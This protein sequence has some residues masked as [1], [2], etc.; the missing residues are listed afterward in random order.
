[1]DPDDRP[2]MAAQRRAQHD[3]L[4]RRANERAAI[5]RQLQASQVGILELRRRREE[6]M[7]QHG[8]EAPRTPP[9]APAFQQPAIQT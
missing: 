2:P 5:A 3:E 7:R 9:V 4:R 1:M 8:H 6:Q